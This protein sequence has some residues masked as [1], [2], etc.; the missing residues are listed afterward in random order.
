MADEKPGKS[1]I[2]FKF[3]LEEDPTAP[4]QIEEKDIEKE[5][6]PPRLASLGDFFGIMQ[7]R[8]AK[9]QL[10]S[11][12]DP[13]GPDPMDE[14]A[15][16]PRQVGELLA[17]EFPLFNAPEIMAI[18]DQIA[19]MKRQEM[20]DEEPD[21]AMMT[22]AGRTWYSV[23]KGHRTYI[24]SETLQKRIERISS[25]MGGAPYEAA[26]TN[27]LKFYD[28]WIQAMESGAV[29]EMYD[30]HGTELVGYSMFDMRSMFS[31]AETQVPE[32]DSRDRIKN[33]NHKHF[34]H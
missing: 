10:A 28:A 20:R 30:E 8:Q 7:S 25:N 11:M 24:M 34:I 19:H 17:K 9:M 14:E 33:L 23:P 27:A 12:R 31:D 18:M 16:I 22:I 3:G 26:M 2:A 13:G 4:Q 29:R 21:P 15:E 6:L 1:R 32:K 5:D